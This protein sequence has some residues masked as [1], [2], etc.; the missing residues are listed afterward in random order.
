[1][2]EGPP[3]SIRELLV[4]MKN[5]S[6][7]MV[8][9]SLASIYFEDEELARLVHSLENKMDD[10]TYSF[11]QS[12]AV[13]SRRREEARRITGLVQIAVSA[14][15]ISNACGDL[16]SLVLRRTKIHSVLKE[17]LAMASERLTKVK[18]RENSHL[19]GKKLG[20]LR[21][22]SS[23]GVWVLAR[24]KGGKYEIPEKETVLEVGDLLVVKGPPE[25][26]RKIRL[27]A[28]EPP[29][30]SKTSPRL[31]SMKKT[32]AE[33]RDAAVLSVD[34]AY[35]SVLL[36]LPEPAQLVREIEKKFDILSYKLWSETLRLAKKEK[37][38]LTSILETARYLERITDSADYIVD[39]ILRGIEPHP[40]LTEAMKEVNEKISRIQ[41][42]PGS[43]LENRSIGE[44][45]LWAT[46]GSYILFI[47][48]GEKFIYTPSRKTKILAGDYLVVRGA[49]AG[50]EQIRRLAEATVSEA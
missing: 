9:L 33:M 31:R 6:D 43:I 29:L 18:V 28:G 1:M 11:F 36:N 3:R 20:E 13:V 47:Q 14:E 32:L 38:G 24:E 45:D 27:M 26:I 48:R 39:F 37:E 5:T 19:A 22:P 35:S 42:K 12:S 21:L 16:S 7:W 23:I 17:A 10:L 8:D 49:Y 34:L 15:N 46:T 2:N 50:I 40:V 30:L 44:L 4:E 25:S 41:V